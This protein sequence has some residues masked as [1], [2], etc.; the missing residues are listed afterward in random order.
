MV[1]QT[2]FTG[3][4]I[5]TWTSLGDQ[6][7]AYHCP[8]AKQWQNSDETRCSSRAEAEPGSSLAMLGST[9]SILGCEWFLEE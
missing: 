5:R 9:H 3:P 7:S 8:A 2:T 6:C 4:G 1:E